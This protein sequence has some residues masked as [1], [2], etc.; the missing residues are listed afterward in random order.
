ME[1]I[2]KYISNTWKSSKQGKAIVV[3]IVIVFL[4]LCCGLIGIF[5]P[6]SSPASNPDATPDIKALQTSAVQTVMAGVPTKTPLPTN[7]PQPTETPLPTATSTPPPQPIVLTGSGD[8]VV[9][10]KKWNGPAILKATHTGG[11]NFIVLNYAS[12]GDKIDLLIN[13]IGN[14][15]GTLPLDFLDSQRTA[16]L[17]ITAGGQWELTIFP[18]QNARRETVPSSIQGTGDDVVVLTD[19]APDLLKI[20]ATQ[21]EGN[22]ILMTYGTKGRDL[23]VNEIAPYSGTVMTKPGTYLLVITATGPWSIEITAK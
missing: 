2:M 1:G 4:C 5:A 6:K 22:F 17:E 8:S 3:A 21:A 20:N 11:G 9:D 15:A 12:S 10:V 18:I 7:T 23:L 19:A 16:R 13:T 14:Y